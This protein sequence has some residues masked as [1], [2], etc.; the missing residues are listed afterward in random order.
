MGGIETPGFKFESMALV[1]TLKAWPLPGLVYA[2]RNPAGQNIHA[3]GE[4][5]MI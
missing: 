4:M 1:L 2:L 5:E 3:A